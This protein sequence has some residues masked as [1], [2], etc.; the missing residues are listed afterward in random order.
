M[1]LW[2]REGIYLHDM[3]LR[4]LYERNDWYIDDMQNGITMWVRDEIKEVCSR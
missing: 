1:V 4:L 2:G 3:N